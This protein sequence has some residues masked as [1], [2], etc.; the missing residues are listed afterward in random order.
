MYLPSAT[1]QDRTENHRCQP[2]LHSGLV[3]VQ[4]QETGQVTSLQIHHT[5]D[6][7]CFHLLHSGRRYRALYAKTTRH[8]NGFFPQAGHSDEHLTPGSQSVRNNP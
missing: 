5:L 8:K 2:A 4:S 7:T 3:H 1:K 6:I